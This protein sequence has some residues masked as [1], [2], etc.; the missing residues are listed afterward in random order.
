MFSKQL[1]IF[2]FNY[3]KDSINK[4]KWDELDKM[5]SFWINL[6]FHWNLIM[7]LVQKVKHYHILLKVVELIVE[8]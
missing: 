2:Q 4:N 1:N 7:I 5:E 3:A 8:T 6:H